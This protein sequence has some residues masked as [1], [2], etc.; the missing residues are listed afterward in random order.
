MTVEELPFWLVNVPKN[1]WPAECPDYLAKQGAKNK[2]IL[3][4]RDEDYHRHTWQEVTAII[5]KAFKSAS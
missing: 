2:K 3:S 5:S 4:T 1:E